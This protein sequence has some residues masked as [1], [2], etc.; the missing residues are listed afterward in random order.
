MPCE[1]YKNALIEVAA[2]GAAPQG[3]LRAH[4][5]ACASCRA[6]FADEQS[7]FGA[8]DSGL[9][10]PANIEV[11]VTLL[12][13]VRTNLDE[14][15][16]T[17]HYWIRPLAL[18]SAGVAL[19]SLLLWIVRPNRPTPENLAKQTPAVPAPA[20]PSA[21]TQK[22]I[23]LSTVQTTSAARA[24]SHAPRYSTLIRAVASSN[25]EVLVPPDEREG[26]AKLVATLSERRD[27]AAAL[28]TQRPEKKDALVTVDPLRIADI[29][30]KPLERTEAETSDG[31]GEKR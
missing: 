29:E 23:P 30:I 31:T 9:R 12:P 1:H 22:D 21:G 25:P 4:L 7:L 11:P 28:L 10:A 24:H 20:F 14:T 3:E 27:V 16:T 17:Q 26:L 6:V 8:I 19:A 18:A 2:S 13:R 15:M 5:D